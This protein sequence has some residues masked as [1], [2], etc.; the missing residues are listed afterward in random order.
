M[1]CEEC[2]ALYRR[3]TCHGIVFWN[4]SVYTSK[5]SAGCSGCRIRE[6]ILTDL[7]IET[8]GLE[9]IRGITVGKL[10]LTFFLTDGTEIEKTWQQPSRASSWTAE[11]KKTASERT[12]I[13]RKEQLWHD[14]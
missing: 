3:C 1:V 8:A 13:Q 12:R 4:C 2:G 6:D 10:R 14:Q 11:M 5:G 7:T 9:S